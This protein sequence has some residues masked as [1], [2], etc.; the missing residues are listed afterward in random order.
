MDK[1]VK[2]L[3]IFMMALLGFAQSR[4]GKLSEPYTLY[5][6]GEKAY[7]YVG[8][9]QE[10]VVG[11]TASFTLEGS[12]PY[13]RFFTNDY[14]N[15]IWSKWGTG[16]GPQELSYV[17]TSDDVTKLAANNYKLT[18]V[19]YDGSCSSFS[20]SAGGGSTPDGEPGNT[21]TPG[22]TGNPED[23]GSTTFKQLTDLPTIYLQIYKLNADG[24]SDKTVTETI[25][26]SGGDYHTARIVIVDKNKTIMERDEETEIR[27][28]GN[29]TWSGDNLKNPYRLKFFNK[30][31]LLSYEAEDG[32]IVNNYANAKSWTLMSNKG[33]FSLIRNALSAELGKWMG[34]PFVPAY[35]FVDLVINGSY[36]GTY[37]ISDQVQVSKDRVNVNS[38]TGWLLSANRGGGYEEDPYFTA[39]GASF[40]IKNPEKSTLTSSG[41]TTDP[42]FDEMKAW[43][44]NVFKAEW[45]NG[46]ETFKED[47]LAEYF[48]MESLANYIIGIDITGDPDGAI[49]NF[50]MY[51]EDD[52]SSKMKFGPMWDYDLAY[53]NVSHRNCAESHFF[54]DCTYGW[55]YKVKQIY[56]TPVLM[57]AL[58]KRWQEVYP[59]LA[60]YLE[61][62]VDELDAIIAESQV[63]NFAANKAGS[64]AGSNTYSS[65][66][67][68]VDTLRA[69]IRPHIE[70]L[71]RAYKADYKSITGIDPDDCKHTYTQNKYT[72]NTDGTYSQACDKCGAT[73]ADSEKFYKF[74]VYPESAAV[75]TV[76]AKSWTPAEDKPN[77]IALVTLP[78]GME[79]NIPGYNIV[80]STKNADG[81]QTCA[82]FRLTDGHP[83]YS[84]KKFVAAKATYTRT[85]AANEEYGMMTLPFKH[86]NASNEDADFYHIASVENGKINLVAIDPSIEG[87]ASAYLPVIFKRKAGKTSITVTGTDITVKK[88][89]TTDKFNS[90]CEGWTIMG[91]IENANATA[92]GLYQLS[93]AKTGTVTKV[94]NV[95]IAPFRA[96]L[97]TTS[98]APAPLTFSIPSTEVT[99][100]ISDLVNTIE[101]MR[102]GKATKSDVENIVNKLLGR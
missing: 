7:D 43:M 35:K 58:W 23:G 90:T 15:P 24:T 40:N 37:Q 100:T 20:I 53:G 92:E 85:L 34:M 86:Q 12:N 67:A 28:R 97:T 73:K 99:Y 98:S 102:N 101:Q 41:V 17:L 78:L 76:Y 8:D 27:G 6:W 64:V 21:G 83:Y 19:I 77:S 54:D 9:A 57:K 94:N 91:A 2:V 47:G 32:T 89:T 1:A 56:N 11:A 33:D 25:T 38:D 29:S 14:N 36:A 45:V 44:T 70:W 30:T 46:K 81:N 59:G 48:D 31:K 74:E 71:N 22:N 96:Y 68:A 72:A 82:D 50:Y 80:N 10:M 51:R 3:C 61:G 88:S 66:E 62:K 13:G 84:D 55:G 49:D 39:A 63:K 93:D 87:N 16:A 42:K 60:D 4:A 79:A 5:G 75:E 69:W 26:A 52:P 95:S 65:H 18:I